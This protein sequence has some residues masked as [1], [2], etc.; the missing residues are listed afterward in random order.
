MTT[1]LEVLDA[2]DRAQEDHESEQRNFLRS[3]GWTYT[4]QTPGSFWLHEKKMPDGRTI[5]V[6]TEHA[7]SIERYYIE[8]EQA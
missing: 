5:L 6:D 2:M 3:R 7:M 8:L 4:C 1:P